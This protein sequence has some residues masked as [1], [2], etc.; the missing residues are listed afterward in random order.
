MLGDQIA[1]TKLLRPIVVDPFATNARRNK[2]LIVN[3]IIVASKTHIFHA[4]SFIPRTT[5]DPQNPKYVDNL[6]T[7]KASKK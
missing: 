7:F 6:R 3:N 4:G 2:H 5:K 1:A